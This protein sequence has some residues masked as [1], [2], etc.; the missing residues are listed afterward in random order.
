MSNNC[1]GYN[2][3]IINN[4]IHCNSN[5][6]NVECEK[7]IERRE[8]HKNLSILSNDYNSQKLREN[9]NYYKDTCS[10]HYN[11]ANNEFP[12]ELG[13]V[14]KVINYK[15]IREIQQNKYNKNIY[16]DPVK[17]N[18][19]NRIYNKVYKSMSLG[20][21]NTPAGRSMA[22]RRTIDWIRRFANSQGTTNT[23]W[24]ATTLIGSD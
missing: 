10:F 13:V 12:N 19:Y 22:N 15:K 17:Q 4:R 11:N 9:P 1:L 8:V 3:C 21:P 6:K 24:P 23:G 16:S 2:N 7:T 18:Y 5:M 14:H 20:L